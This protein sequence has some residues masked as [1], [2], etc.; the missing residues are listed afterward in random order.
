MTLRWLLGIVRSG[1]LLEERRNVSHQLR[2]P[3]VADVIAHYLEGYKLSHR[4]NILFANG[5]LANVNRAGQCR[6]LRPH[7]RAK[8]RV[9]KTVQQKQKLLKIGVFLREAGIR[10][11]RRFPM[12]DSGHPISPVSKPYQ[13]TGSRPV[14]PNHF[15]RGL[16]RPMDQRDP[17][18]SLG[19]CVTPARYNRSN[20]LCPWLPEPGWARMNFSNRLARAAWVRSIVPATRGWIA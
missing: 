1:M 12:T 20:N 15:R 13:I 6:A 5:R 4:P 19:Q 9:F 8:S 10:L 11:G 3:A 16:P 18:K 7:E 17:P 14:A 2:D